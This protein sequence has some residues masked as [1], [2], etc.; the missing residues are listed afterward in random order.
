M[1]ENQEPKQPAA[2]A[3]ASEYIV[4]SVPE[5]VWLVKAATL[6][7]VITNDPTYDNKA[8]AA[9]K[10]TVAEMMNCAGVGAA[11]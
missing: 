4:I 3:A 2:P 5:Y 1:N 6:L 11:Q 8:L 10:A 9:V 7:E